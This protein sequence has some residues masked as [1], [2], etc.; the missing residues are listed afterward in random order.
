MVGDSAPES[1]RRWS[2]RRVNVLYSYHVGD[3]QHAAQI[4]HV[5]WDLGT[6]ESPE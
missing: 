3:A 6:T 2:H 4:I 1:S 5:S